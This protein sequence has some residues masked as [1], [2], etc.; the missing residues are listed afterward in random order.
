MTQ[1]KTSGSGRWAPWWVYVIVLV[2]ANYAK[3]AMLGDGPVAINVAAT[4]ALIAVGVVII[5]ALYRSFAKGSA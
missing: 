4:L 3:Q 2:P 5:T 1:N